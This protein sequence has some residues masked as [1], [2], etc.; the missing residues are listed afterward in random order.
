[1]T[2]QPITTDL[3]EPLHQQEF[4]RQCAV[5]ELKKYPA[6]AGMTSAEFRAAVDPLR[7]HLRDLPPPTEHRIPF[8]LVVGEQVVGL[9]PAAEALEL[10]AGGG[11]TDMTPEDLAR[12]RP[13]P[14][15]TETAAFQLAVDVSTGPEFLGATPDETLPQILG[16]GRSPLTVAEGV[17]VVTMFPG[18]L[19]EQ[20]CFMMA[21]SRCGDRRVTALW[22]S[23]KR[24]RLGWCWAGN[25]HTWLGMAHLSYR[26]G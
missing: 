4:D 16:S 6:L 13:I 17:A 14:A 3:G 21:G 24:P 19:R 10:P 18:I 20:N 11:F 8:V 15:V 12:F 2:I 9:K 7:I 23:K 5:L 26:L 1:M 22:V 25:H